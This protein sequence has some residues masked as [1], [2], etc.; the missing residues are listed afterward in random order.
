MKDNVNVNSI[1]YSK[2]RKSKIDSYWRKSFLR[3]LQVRTM[4][5]KKQRLWVLNFRVI[6]S[7][8]MLS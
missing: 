4:V 7:F 5:A 2:S 8:F 3:D 1:K 6:F